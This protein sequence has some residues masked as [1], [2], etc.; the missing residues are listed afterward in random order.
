MRLRTLQWIVLCLGASI[1][2]WLIY[3]QPA[4][5]EET[6][7]KQIPLNQYG[8]RS[9]NPYVV[10]RFEH[11]G[12]TIDA[13]IVPGRPTPPKGV[14]RAT[15]SAPQRDIQAGINI[16][17][18]VPA[19]TWSFGCSATSAAM[20]FGHYDIVGYNNMY[21]GP[22]NGGVFPMTNA[23]WGTTVIS[24]ESRALCPLSATMSG[25]DG[26]TSR[27][28]VDDYWIKY[29]S[30]ADDPFITN[31]WTE[32]T[33]GECTADYMRTNQ[34]KWH[35]SDGSTLFF[36]D[37]DGDPLYDFH[38]TYWE[39]YFYR[40]GCHGMRLFAESRGYTVNT[41][42]SQYIYGYDGNTRG[43]TFDEFKTEIDAGRPVLIQLRGHTMLGYG[44]DDTDSTVPII[45]I[46]DTWDY[47]D[48]SM[49]W[50]GEY[51]G[52]EHIGVTVVRLA[53]L[54][55]CPDCPPDGI[56]D[57]V[58]YPAGSDCTCTNAVALTIGANV[59]IEAGATVTFIAPIVTFQPGF[60]F[61]SAGGATLNVHQ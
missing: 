34:S 38:P 36:Y 10:N 35:N 60:N 46:H 43:F 8:V 7:N 26:R 44:Y 53:Q 57:N 54:P 50:G 58:T 2:G 23:V 20:M 52:M 22:T 55:D 24:G 32:H 59:T 21:T 18:N 41:N 47:N 12:K 39:G 28:H 30:E 17:P 9:S 14:I 13:V 27:G 42:F 15:V 5:S 16:I 37:G 6:G 61:S 49:I 31:G 51:S 33:L 25:L 48:H 11:N 3:V 40:D 45:Y 1:L 4:V 19:M 56:I 29:A